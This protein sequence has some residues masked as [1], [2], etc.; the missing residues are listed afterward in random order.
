MDAHDTRVGAY[1]IIVRDQRILL[2]HWNEAGNENW[3]LP[4]GGLGPFEDPAD[5]AVREVLEE[6]GY[7]VRLDRLLGIDSEHIPTE[8][9]VHGEP[10]PLHSLRIL[11]R[12]TIV[13]GE[14][15]REIGGSTD[16]A[17]WVPLDEVEE[18]PRVRLVEVGLRLWRAAHGHA[19]PGLS[20]AAP[21]RKPL[22]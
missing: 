10:R 7:H 13:G 12:A 18:L 1:G 11:Y 17:R 21:P 19:A 9:R 15:R 3:T 6:T 8:K 14:L 22:P 20:G 16:D 2:A 4:G 5:A